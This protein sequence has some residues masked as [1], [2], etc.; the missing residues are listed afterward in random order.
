MILLLSVLALLHVHDASASALRAPGPIDGY[1]KGGKRTGSEAMSSAPSSARAVKKQRCEATE[2][3]EKIAK[4]QE[5][6]AKNGASMENIEIAGEGDGRGAFASAEIPPGGLLIRVPGGL[7]MTDERAAATTVGH[8]ITSKGGTRMHA[9]QGWLVAQKFASGAGCG[10]ILE[11]E[12][13][14]GDGNDCGDPVGGWQ[15]YIDIL[16]DAYDN[17]LWWDEEERARLFAGTTMLN[18]V[19]V[20]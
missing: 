8:L 18:F 6:L 16:P 4:F 3:D 1:Q 17:P 12:K 19:Q 10:A 15:P 5:W 14:V 11:K 7:I 9:L 2:R 13:D 20:T